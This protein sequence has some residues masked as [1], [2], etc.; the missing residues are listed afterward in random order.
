LVTL[1]V[2]N[3]LPGKK[4]SLI[5]RV[6]KKVTMYVCGVT[7]YDYA[8]LGHGRCYVTFDIWYRLLTF[9]GYEVTY[10]RNITDI[11]DKLL[12]RA[13]LEL[14]DRLRYQEL[15]QRYTKLYHEDMKA[16]GCLT[17][18]YE[19]RA[20]ETVSAMISLIESLITKGHAY[21]VDGD[22]Y[23]SV[24][25][26]SLY[27]ALSKRK[28]EDMMAGARVEIN[29]RKRDPLDFVLWKAEA[30]G[31]F[32]ESP[33][34]Y[35]RPGWHI[36]CSAMARTYL[37]DHLDMHGG[38][39]DLIF[40]H[41]EN[42]IAQ[43]E[44]VVG[45]PFVKYWL[46]NGFVTINKEKMSKSL[47]NFFTLRDIF[48]RYHPMVVRLYFAT[49]HYRLPLEFSFD[50]LEVTYK[51]YQRLAKLLYNHAC[52]SCGLGYAYA[53]TLPI[54]QTMLEVLADDLNTTGMFGIIFEHWGVVK[55]DEALQCAVKI[56]LRQVVGLLLEPI[57]EKTA[58][59]TPAI[60]KLLKEREQARQEKDW[61]RADDLRKQLLALGIELHDQKIG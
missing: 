55:D 37:G 59:I 26:F 46:H 43:S 15:A 14:G 7:P 35:G 8:H 34:G 27:G 28:L 21:V 45:H 57:P 25:A 38:G 3:T 58:V 50:D 6:G 30:S 39:M 33:W 41:H 12:N 22:V 52:S 18:T 2:T 16:L 47:G 44:G 40:P 60:E 23:F 31:K 61:K 19:P 56:I 1:A 51:M 13:E 4:E 36:E 32:W 17:P 48:Q 29:E 54:T 20:T 11:D 53:Q 49:H 9:L 42:E 10:C 24:A 5:P